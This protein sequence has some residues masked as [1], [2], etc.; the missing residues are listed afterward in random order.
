MM[1][2]MM[3]MM[4]TMMMMTMMMIM[5]MMTMMTMMPNIVRP[6]FRHSVTPSL[7][8]SPDQSDPSGTVTK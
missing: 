6:H 2:M 7:V 3:M 5:M 8:A 1:M 4:M